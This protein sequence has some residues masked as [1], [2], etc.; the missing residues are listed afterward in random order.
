MLASTNLSNH[1][2]KE[3]LNDERHL[4]CL[5]AQALKGEFCLITSATSTPKLLKLKEFFNAPYVRE[6]DV[7]PPKLGLEMAL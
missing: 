3:A 5:H 2:R 1:A 4:A 6:V 7:L